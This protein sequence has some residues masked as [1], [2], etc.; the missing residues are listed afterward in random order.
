MVAGQQAHLHHAVARKPRHA[1]R[2]AG[3][4]RRLHERRDGGLD[5]AGA[6]PSASASI[7]IWYFIGMPEQDEASV[8]RTVEYCEHLLRKFKGRR[9]KPLLCPMI[10][11]LDPAST[12]F[13]YPEKHGYRVFYRTVEEHRR[14]MERASIINRTNY[15]TQWL[16]R[17]D[18]V[19]VGY[20]A[21]QELT[22]LKGEHGFLPRSVVRR[23][24]GQNRRRAR[25]RRRRARGRQHRRSRRTAPVRSRA[26]D[27]RL[28]GA[29]TKRSFRG[30]PTRPTRSTA[31]SAGGGS[32]RRCTD[33]RSSKRWR[34]APGLPRMPEASDLSL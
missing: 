18:L 16:S 28:R 8:K 19:R 1:G 13:E 26:W 31:R 21:V 20:R 3:R 24:L 15:E 30:W 23:I 25:V 17:Y 22:R 27:P 34:R 9:V 12:F 32:T 10:P 29:I 11:F 4:S 2:D 33:R 5:R 7:D 6:R 14:G